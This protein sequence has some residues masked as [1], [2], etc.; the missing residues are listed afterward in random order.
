MLHVFGDCALD[1]QRYELRRTGTL[2]KLRRKV[3][4]LLAY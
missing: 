2:I 1:T 4:D 3:F